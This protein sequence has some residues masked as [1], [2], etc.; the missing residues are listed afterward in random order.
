MLD[1]RDR[2]T[3]RVKSQSCDQQNPAYGELRRTNN[4]LSLVTTK[5]NA[6]TRKGDTGDPMN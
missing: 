5:T 4:P 1:T 6:K 2:G 3:S